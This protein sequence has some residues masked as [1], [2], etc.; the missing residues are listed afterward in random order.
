V[1]RSANPAG[2]R[3]HTI[4]VHR[5]DVDVRYTLFK[6]LGRTTNDDLGPSNQMGRYPL[7][8]HHVMGPVN[9]SDTGHQ[10]RLIANAITDSRKWPLTVHNTHYGLIKDNVVF[11]GVG[12]G[13]VTED[14]NES[15]NECVRN[16]GAA[17]FGDQNPRDMD[18][19]DG[20]I[21]WLNG[22]HVHGDG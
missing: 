12:S 8:M 18:G 10:Y 9:P 6:D 21:F 16:F 11:N 1:I 3:G 4:H 22:R 14:G 19:R 15:N 17:I 7:H 13:F 5:A 20:S 2:T